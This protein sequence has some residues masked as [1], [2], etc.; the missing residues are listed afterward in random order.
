[1]CA[2]SIGLDALPEEAED[3]RSLLE[4]ALQELHA[5]A[6]GIGVA[7]GGPSVRGCADGPTATAD[8]SDS[9]DF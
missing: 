7:V 5:L 6:G 2:Q 1:M 3:V 9:F 8:E 4:G